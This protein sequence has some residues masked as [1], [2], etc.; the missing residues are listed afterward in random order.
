MSDFCNPLRREDIHSVAA[1]IDAQ[2]WKGYRL[3]DTNYLAW[4]LLNDSSRFAGL[5]APE[6][7]ERFLAKMQRDIGGY[8]ALDATKLRELYLKIYAGPVYNSPEALK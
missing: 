7:R 5:Y 8:P 2:V 4:D 1:Q 6:L 3:W